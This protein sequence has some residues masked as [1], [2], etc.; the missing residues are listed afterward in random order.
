MQGRDMEGPWKNHGNVMAGNL[1]LHA[2]LLPG[3]SLVGSVSEGF[4]LVGSWSA[5]AGRRRQVPTRF[6]P[7]QF[8]TFRFRNLL[9]FCQNVAKMSHFWF[10]SH[11]GYISGF[12]EF[13]QNVAK[14]SNFWHFGI[15]GFCAILADFGGFWPIF[16]VT[17]W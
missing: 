16:A 10:W 5:L 17:P 2:W 14:I 9:E 13:C 3:K 6:L 8:Q 12:W 1:F 15:F 4:D 11:F 7:G